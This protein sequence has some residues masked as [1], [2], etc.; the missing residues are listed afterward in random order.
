MERENGQIGAQ[1]EEWLAIPPELVDGALSGALSEGRVRLWALVLDARS[2]PCRIELGDR[3]WQLL[4][5]A[6]VFDA[7]L[8]ELRLFTEQNRNWPPA[9]PLARTL[10]E[11]TLATLSVLL[12]VAV[13]HNI[14]QLDASFLGISPPDWIAIGSAQAG[15][16]LDGEWWRPVTALTLHADGLHLL[17]NLAIGGIF[18]VLLC[19]ELGSGLAWGLLLAAGILGNLAN[20]LVQPPGH[21]SV[22]GSTL[23]FGAVGLLAAIS[24]LRYRR[25]LQRRW[26]LPIAAALALLALLGS[27]GRNTDLGAHLFGFCFGIGLGLMAEHLLG[28]HGRPGRL[29]NALLALVSALVVAAA[30]WGALASGGQ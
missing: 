8:K 1:G 16:I 4:V 2:V 5:P 24:M 22:G 29:F 12:L 25:R 13:F 28:W 10:A 23:V 18:I 19:R 26:P 9:P 17:S 27:E 7:A 21:S 30:W 3:G 20:A 14:V 6:D 15:K 11:N